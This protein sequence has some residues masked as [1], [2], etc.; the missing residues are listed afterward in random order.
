MGF[1]CLWWGRVPVLWEVVEMRQWLIRR[2]T[3][4]GVGRIDM[5]VEVPVEGR[6]P[7]ALPHV[8]HRLELAASRWDAHIAELRQLVDR[9]EAH[10]NERGWRWELGPIRELISSVEVKGRE[11]IRLALRRFDEL[12]PVKTGKTT[13]W[14]AWRGEGILSVHWP[15]DGHSF[16]AKL[17][18]NGLSTTAVLGRGAL[19]V[20]ERRLYWL[21]WRA[22]DAARSND[23]HPTMGTTDLA[24]IFAWAPAVPG[25]MRIRAEYVNLTLE[26]PHVYWWAKALGHVERVGDKTAVL[27]KAFSSPLSA[28]GHVLG[29]GSPQVRKRGRRVLVVTASGKALDVIVR[30]LEGVMGVIG[31]RGRVWVDHRHGYAVVLGLAARRMAGWMIDNTPFPLH[32]LLD[33]ARFGKWERLKIVAEPPRE[34]PA[35]LV[36]GYRWGLYLDSRGLRAKTRMAG[37]TKVVMG[38]GLSP[39]VCGRERRAYLSNTDTWRLIGWAAERDP[40]LLDRLEAYLRRWLD[41]KK[42]QVAEKEL[43]KLDQLRGQQ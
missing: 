15:N 28:L 30:A 7:D 37:A 18:L 38:L 29:D 10:V 9:V 1:P 5:P 12:R 13:M 19:A 6:L 41:T 8:R 21:G 11:R 23:N 42:A 16:V 32:G 31:V 14:L 4:L 22:S 36:D 24:Q 40:T 25:R 27:G 17:R 26:G 33:V 39:R 20:K 35:I 3:I 43:R 2:R 34:A